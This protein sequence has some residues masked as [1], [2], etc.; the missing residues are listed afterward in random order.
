MNSFLS[1]IIN[2][3]MRFVVVYIFKCKVCRDC[4]ERTVLDK[5]TCCFCDEK[6]KSS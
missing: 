2:P 5:D 3:L 1:P 4:G 6:I